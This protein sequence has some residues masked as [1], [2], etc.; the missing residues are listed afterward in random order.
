MH[1][2]NPFDH[3]PCNHYCS[4]LVHIDVAYISSVG[5]D[6]LKELGCD[7]KRNF[8]VMHEERHHLYGTAPCDIV[9]VRLAPEAPGLRERYPLL[10][11]HV[12]DAECQ[13]FQAYRVIYKPVRK[14]ATCGT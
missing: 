4:D 10:F 7:L 8:Q 6:I 13:L 1:L 14:E 11:G 2:C 5:V 9:S 3:Y 12:P